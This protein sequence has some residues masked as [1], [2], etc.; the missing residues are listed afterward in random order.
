MS[1]ITADQFNRRH[2]MNNAR[3]VITATNDD[4]GV[5]RV[6]VRPTPHELIDD[7]PVVQ[8]YG[9]SSHAPVGSEAHMICAKGDRSSTVV[10]A[11]NN[12]DARPRKLA[13]GEVALYTAE[14]DTIVLKNGHVI[15]ITTT[16]TV[17][18]SA[19]TVNIAGQDGGNV[20]VNVTG[21]IHCS[22]TITADTVSAPHG[23]VGS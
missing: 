3:C 23:H 9:V 13:S 18:V 1:G 5:H 12:A 14:G 8:L 6:Q 10:I 15:A 22:G 7:V 4:G 20:T 19:P 11:T 16:G 21:D 17:S 2:L